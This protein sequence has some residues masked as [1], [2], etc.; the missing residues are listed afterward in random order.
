MKSLAIHFPSGSKCPLMSC[1]VFCAYVVT[2]IACYYTFIC[3][4]AVSKCHSFLSPHISAHRITQRYALVNGRLEEALA[5]W[6]LLL[7]SV[8]T[9]LLL[10]SES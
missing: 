1:G 2:H 6:L 4:L 5:A 9:E 10:R 8:K 7:R 3:I